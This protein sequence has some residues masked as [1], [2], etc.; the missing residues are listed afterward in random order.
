MSFF[1][2]LIALSLCQI[3][4][5]VLGV[6]WVARR[7]DEIPL[8]ISA[9]LFYVFSF[10]LWA[11]FLGWTPP[12]DLTNFGFDPLDSGSVLE[13][14][15]IAILGETVLLSV[16]MLAQRRQIDV[17]HTLASPDLLRWL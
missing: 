14:D 17:P 4:W 12:A 16:Y 15:S 2:V 7:R 10:R 1:A 9:V 13:V 5:I 6:L 11:L 8:L 3:G